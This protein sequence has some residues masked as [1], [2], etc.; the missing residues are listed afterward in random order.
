MA[1]G[2]YKAIHGYKVPTGIGELLHERSTNYN[3]RG[4]HILEL[5]KVNTITYALRDSES[6]E[7]MF[8]GFTEEDQQSIA[9]LR[10]GG[11]VDRHESD[12][13]SDISVSSVATEDLSDFTDSEGEKIEETWNVNEDPIEVLPFSVATGPTSGVAENGTAKKF[14]T[15]LMFQNTL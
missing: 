6:E 9:E 2:V 7:G 15:Y 13:E 10:Q 11:I 3:L 12:S 4:K 14:F 5:P 8:L 1:T